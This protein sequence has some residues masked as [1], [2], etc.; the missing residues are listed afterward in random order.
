MG[1]NDRFDVVDVENF[2]KK[3]ADSQL[4]RWDE[5]AKVVQY[6]KLLQNSVSTGK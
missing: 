3:F 2:D 6:S 4:S 1:L 5:H